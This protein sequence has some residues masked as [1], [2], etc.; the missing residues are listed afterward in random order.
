MSKRLMSKKRKKTAL[1]N[2][3]WVCRKWLILEEDWHIDI[4][5]GVYFANQYLKS[6]PVW[7]YVVGAPGSGKTEVLQSWDGHDNIY[8]LTSLTPN[9][10]ISGMISDDDVDPSLIPKL[11]GKVLVIKDFTVILK[12]RHEVASAILSQLRDAYDGSTS[13]AFGTGKEL[14]Y[15]AK[16]G[17]IAAVT[18]EI[19]KHVGKLSALGERFL[20][21][22]LPDIS[23]AEQRARAEQ[24]CSE[25][26]VKRMESEIKEAAHMVLNFKPP[27]IPE[28]PNLCKAKII[29]AAQFVARARTTVDRN[30]HDREIAYLPN[31]EHPTRIAKQLCDLARGIAIARGIQKV[32]VNEVRLVQKVAIGSIASNRLSLLK[33]LAEIYPKK[34]SVNIVAQLLNV[35]YGAIRIWLYDL[36]VLNIVTKYPIDSTINTRNQQ[37][38][39]KVEYSK[40]L[41]DIWTI[42]SH[43][44]T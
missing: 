34:A 29:D 32:T 12:E 40:L 38:R 18:H 21:C 30:R 7:I 11:D 16:F 44:T 22:R 27:S 43:H 17:V 23:E 2:Y 25:I 31:P 15:T 42:N 13:K 10:L 35:S 24:A 26:D 3:K 6:K 41:R 33:T 39:L 9:T 19:D 5:F 4:Q 14:K 36:Y 37:F 20:I 1:E 28:L 8:M